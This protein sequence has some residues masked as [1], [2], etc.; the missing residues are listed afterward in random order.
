MEFGIEPVQ[1]FPFRKGTNKNAVD[2]RIAMDATTLV[3]TRSPVDHFILVTGDS[4][5]IPVV[6]E[7]KRHGPHVAVIGVK[8]STS[9]LFAGTVTASSTLRRFIAAEEL[10]PDLGSI[11]QIG[12]HLAQLLGQKQRIKF[13][14]VKPLLTR[15]LGKPFDPTIYGC[16]NTGDFLRRNSGTLQIQVQRGEFDWEILPESAGLSPPSVTP[17]AVSDEDFYKKLLISQKPMLFIVPSDAWFKVT[18]LVYEQLCLSA[19]QEKPFHYRE[20]QELLYDQTSNTDV[21]FPDRTVPSTMFQLYSSG[22]FVSADPDDKPLETSFHWDKAANLHP[23]I[24]RR[25]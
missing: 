11:K 24:N 15:F 23:G 20:F 12:N 10:A 9:E 16:E 17:E 2:M 8:G 5:F 3:S 7:L 22:C 14:A 6:V 4:D 25:R 13:A 18:D 1:V 19:R 21:S